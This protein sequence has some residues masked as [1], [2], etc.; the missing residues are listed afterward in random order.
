MT[1]FIPMVLGFLM[2]AHA[3]PTKPNIVLL[4]ADDQRADTIH[5]LG[6]NQII[7]PNLDALVREGTSF[8]RAY[9]MGGLQ[10][11]VCV[12]SRA[13]MLSGKSLYRVSEQ[14]KENTT[15]PMALRQAGYQ[16]FATGKWHNGAPAL[17]AS[18]PNAKSIY[19]GG[20]SDQFGTPMAD[21]GPDGKMTNQRKPPEHCS[22]V[23]ADEAIRFLKNADKDKPFAVYVAF[24]SPHDPRQAPQKYLDMYDSSKVTLPPNYLPEHPFNNGELIIRDE[25]LEK[26]PR[27]K[28]AIQKHLA[29]YYAI[30]S[31]QDAQIGRIVQTLKEKGVYENT[32]IV[33]AAD[34][35]LAIG[36]HGLMGKQSVYEHSMR[37][38]LIVK[39]P[40][41]QKNRRSNAMCLTIDLFPTFCEVAGAKAPPVVE[42]KSLVPVLSGRETTHRSEILTGYRHLMRGF[43][44]DR[45]KLIVNIAVNKTQLFDLQDDPHELRDLSNE[46]GMKE[47]VGQLMEGMKKAQQSWG[48]KQSLTPEKAL[49]LK[50]DFSKVPEEKAKKGKS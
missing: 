42:G 34:N 47:K 46:A 45:Y 12:P 4:F 16:T 22:E 32:L 11:A 15:W 24:K 1:S 13:M 7:T 41:V 38:P 5:A 25:R 30:I 18:F 29:E 40:G 19:L 9:I 23:F 26:W 37:I 28:S 21:V 49:P 36:S 3:Q 20:M 35:G 17:A 2:F 39:G 27:S 50:F 33:F 14:L 44:D 31:H 8:D 10:G 6:N 43:R 48:D